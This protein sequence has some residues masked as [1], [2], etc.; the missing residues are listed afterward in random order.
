MAKVAIVLT[1]DAVL[2]KKLTYLKGAN[3]KKAIRKA[4]RAALKPLAAATKTAAP[5]RTGQLRR[6]IKVKA[7]RRTRKSV[8]A[9]VTTERGYYAGLGEAFYA[10]FIEWGWK[11]A[12]G[13]TAVSGRHMMKKT[14]KAKQSSVLADYRGRLKKLIMH[15]AWHKQVPK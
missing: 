10:K 9:R 14:A 2:N 13:R 1:G 4:S 8:G 3:V 15:I 11:T 12:G 5:R 6:S 7:L